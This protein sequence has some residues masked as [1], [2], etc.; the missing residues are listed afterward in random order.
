MTSGRSRLFFVVPHRMDRSPSQ[1]YR[2]EQFLSWFQANGFSTEYRPL[3]DAKDDPIFYSKGNLHG[4]FMIMVRAFFRRWRDLLAVERNDIVFLH[5]EAFM[6]RGTFFEQL[7]RKRTSKLIFDFDDA[8]WLMDVSEHNRSLRWLKGPSKTNSIIRMADVVIAGNDY[9]ATYARQFS[10]N[11]VVI[12]TV[13]DT[14][15]Y[16]PVPRSL[17]GPVIIGWTGSKTSVAYLMNAAPMLLRLQ[18]QFGNRVKFR[19]ISDRDV[20][21]PGLI[22]DNVRWSSKEETSQ[23]AAFDLGIMPMPDD[24]WSR[25]KCGFKGLQYMG[26]GIPSIMSRVGVNISMIRDGENGFLA[27]G[28]EEWVEKVGRLVNDPELRARMGAEARRTVEQLY[29]VKAWR[30]EYLHLFNELIQR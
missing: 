29:S 7:L 5:R 11:V 15:R 23:L 17:H 14:D 8:I 4:K 1:R 26:M 3:L 10:R 27:N 21:I 9:L 18:E 30:N 20:V 19:F 25:G 6:L 13:I 12:P 2:I 28:T 24:D 22:A 16:T